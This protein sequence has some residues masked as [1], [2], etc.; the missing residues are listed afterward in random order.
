MSE[1]RENGENTENSVNTPAGIPPPPF[2]FTIPS[3]VWLGGGEAGLD[4]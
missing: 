4:I 2:I 3:R 1:K